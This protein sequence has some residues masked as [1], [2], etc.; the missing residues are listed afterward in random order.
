M[1]DTRFIV[2]SF[3]GADSRSHLV[4]I[5]RG[6]SEARLMTVLAFSA[7]EEPLHAAPF[8][9]CSGGGRIVKGLVVKDRFR[10]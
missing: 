4:E 9:V 2:R 8:M 7:K 5:S 6:K 1:S 10:V 3:L